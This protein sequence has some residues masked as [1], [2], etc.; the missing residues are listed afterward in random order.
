M[1]LQRVES[2]AKDIAE[3]E[4][5]LKALIKSLKK[6]T[7]KSLTKTRNSKHVRRFDLVHRRLSSR[8][9]QFCTN[10]TINPLIVKFV[11]NWQKNFFM[12]DKS[13]QNL[14]PNIEYRNSKQYQMTK[15]QIFK[16]E[17]VKL[18]TIELMPLL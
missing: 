12:A 17:R 2:P 10:F 6:Q 11:Q 3:S 14:N 13:L 1:I 18:F 15:I 16:R 9:S 7:Q 5:M 4:R 8:R